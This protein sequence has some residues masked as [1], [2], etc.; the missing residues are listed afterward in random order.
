MDVAF[1]IISRTLTTTIRQRKFSYLRLCH[2]YLMFMHHLMYGSPQLFVSKAA[3][4]DSTKF[5]SVTS[6]FGSM[7]RKIRATKSIMAWSYLKNNTPS[8]GSMVY[9]A[10][11]TFHLP[12][13][14]HEMCTHN[15]PFSVNALVTKLLT[16]FLEDLRVC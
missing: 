1:P 9:L 12:R 11:I 6:D 5:G 15:Q 4:S 14:I 13:L 10:L 2:P 8:T 3:F 7:A 16:F